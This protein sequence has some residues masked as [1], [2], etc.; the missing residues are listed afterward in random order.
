MGLVIKGIEFCIYN[1]QK[2]ENMTNHRKLEIQHIISITISII[3]V[4][5]VIGSLII[6]NFPNQKS[7]Y[8]AEKGVLNLQDWKI[9]G[10]GNIKLD[11]E[12]EFYP[13]LLLKPEETKAYGFKEYENIKKY[14]NVPGTWKDY[15]NEEGSPDGSGTYRIIVRVPEDEVY[16]IKTRTIRTASCVYL[17]GQEVASVGSLSIN[18]EGFRRGSK[19]RVVAGNSLNKEIELIIHVSNYDYPT[20]GII[21]SIEFGTFES[22]MESNN[23]S[24]ALDALT[25]SVCLT[26]C[27]Y[28]LIIYSQRRKERY[29]IYFSGMN[30][31]MGIY[32]STMNEQLLDLVYN[33]NYVTRTAIQVLTMIM[34]ILCFSQFTHCFFSNQGSNKIVNRISIIIFVTL[35]IFFY[36]PNTPLLIYLGYLHAVLLGLLMM[37]YSYIFYI[38]LKEIY[39]KAD[40]L[41]YILIITTSMFSYWFIMTLKILFEIDLGNIPILLILLLMLSVAAL[42]SHRLQLDYQ[43]ASSLSEKLIR[44]DKLKDE[45][46]AK[47][48]HELRT[49][50][51][52]ILNLTK[53]LLEGQ[54][55][56]LNSQQQEDLFFINQEGQRLTRLVEDLLDA[57]QIKSGEIKLRLS[58]IEPYKI[59]EDILKEMRILIPE[60]KS[61]VLKNQIPRVFP[62]LRA[63]SDKFRQIIYNL[64][65]NAIKY[66][67]E[68]EV[69]VSASVIDRQAEIKVS[70]TGIGIEEKYFK[71]VFDIFYQKNEEGQRIGLGLG[72]SIVRHLVES[73][74][75]E[76]DVESIYGKGSSFK[77]TLPIY[78]V[79]IKQQDGMVSIEEDIFK[80]NNSIEKFPK[81][82][83]EKRNYIGKPMVLIADDEPLNQKILWDI[84]EQLEFNVILADSGEETLDILKRNEI[85][86]IILDFMLPDMSG[87]RVCEIVR[88]EYS[89]V[90]LPILILTASGKT[91]DL[92][93]AFDY[94]AN[95]FQRK[96]IDSEELK[97]RIQSLLLMKKSVEEGLE[98]EFQYFYSQISPH[99][100]YNTINTIIG[101]SYKDSGKARKALSNLSIYFRGKLDVHRKKGLITLES[102]LELIIAYL[103]IEQ[104]RYG[105]GL[106]IEYNI[107]E[108]IRAMI[109][110][111]TLQPIVEN[112]IGH[113]LATKNNSGI[114]KIIVKRKPKGFISIRIEDNGVGMT[115]EKQQEILRGNN[116]RVGFTNV[117][118][119]IKILKGATLSL[120]SKLGEGTKVEIVIPEVR[121]N[122]DHFN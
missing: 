22:I 13:D 35:A 65:H 27:I 57:S 88:Q 83:R 1:K 80:S 50:L 2:G 97:S 42:M 102:E 60:N 14:V 85:D 45:F 113:G 96:P 44:Y 101:L 98:K 11:G 9:D 119:K 56:A 64:V 34:V 91:I 75:G 118:E 108:G 41:E 115:Y 93:N 29:L 55:G 48:S 53:N 109:P 21:K 30:F 52:V 38:L 67:K 100:L 58:S 84:M 19:Y 92:M 81:L 8:M 107:E 121:Y 66:T 24:R 68:G 63:D 51:H 46:L 79:K 73:Q 23:K 95:D 116:Q 82:E 105:E 32:L 69:V 25:I 47:A 110:P 103:E 94:G 4:L 114:V 20:G 89:M 49:P 99:F 122:E 18:K 112:A 39:N 12:W 37:R 104:M 59:V 36:N 6:I 40:S 117:V 28:F 86:L 106:K 15:L 76:I 16:G 7:K 90:E 17:N 111:L 54:K 70:D 31:F 33:Y 71:E 5:M 74:G 62:A 77:F 61:I 26:L 43:R 78:D 87:D 10:E 120:E 72:L 3:V